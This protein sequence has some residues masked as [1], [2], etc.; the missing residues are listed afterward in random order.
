M[1][2]GRKK[3]NNVCEENVDKNIKSPSEKH[4]LLKRENIITGCSRMTKE[5]TIRKVGQM[6]ADSGYV[7]ENYIEGMIEREKS[8]STNIG[9]A[10]ALPHGT[11]SVKKEVISSGIA[12]MTFPEGTDWGGEDVKLVIGI[13]GE[14]GTHLEILSNIAMK[15]MEQS[16]VDDLVESNDVEKIYKMFVEE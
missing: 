12:V 5:D 9:N 10:V 3:K 2:F 8:F 13:A 15:L 6:L 11:E 16:V 14:G 1:F 4:E 7:N